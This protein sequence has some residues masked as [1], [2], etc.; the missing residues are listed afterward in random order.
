[1]I[2]EQHV[3]FTIDGPKYLRQGTVYAHVKIQRHQQMKF[4]VSIA[5]T[6]F[7]IGVW[8]LGCKG[9]WEVKLDEE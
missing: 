9:K 6:F 4:R 1:M 3:N 5:H 8:V 7:R 2:P